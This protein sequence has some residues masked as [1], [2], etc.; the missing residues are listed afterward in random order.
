MKAQLVCI[1]MAISLLGSAGCALNY[2]LRRTSLVQ[3]RQYCSF[4]DERHQEKYFRKVAKQELERE[5]ATAMAN[6]DDYTCDPYS[7]DQ[8]CGFEDGFVDYVMYGGVGN[9]PSLPPRR[10][11]RAKYQNGSGYQAIQDWYSG[12]RQGAAVAQASG[13]RDCVIMQL[14]DGL[15]TST[16]PTYV[17]Q[18]SGLEYSGFYGPELSETDNSHPAKGNSAEATDLFTSSEP[19]GQELPS[20]ENSPADSKAKPETIHFPIITAPATPT[21]YH[22]NRAEPLSQSRPTYLPNGHLMSGTQAVSSGGL[23]LVSANETDSSEAS[24]LPLATQFSFES[25]PPLSA[26]PDL[27]APDHSTSSTPTQ[28]APIKRLPA[29]SDGGMFEP[30]SDSAVTAE[31][32]LMSWLAPVFESDA[33]AS[34]TSESASEQFAAQQASFVVPASSSDVAVGEAAQM[35]MPG[36]ESL[37]QQ[38]IPNFATRQNSQFKKIWPSIA[39]VALLVAGVIYLIRRR[40]R[41]IMLALRQLRQSSDRA[42]S[43]VQPRLDSLQT[44]MPAINQVENSLHTSIHA[45]TRAKVGMM[46]A[47]LGCLTSG[48]ASLTNPVLNGIPVRRL[49]TEL[50]SAPNRD[51]LQTIPLS[52]LRQQQPENYV[53]DAGDVIGVFVAGVFPLTSPE[54]P[55]PIPPVYFPS[56]IDPLG[57]GL[58]PSLGY[59]VTIRNDGT[60]AL[61]FVEPIKLDGLTIEE[62]NVRIRAAYLDQGI[63]QPGREEVLVTLMQPRRIRVL[64]FR[65]EVGGFS[66]GGRGDITGN[67]KLGTGHIVDLRAYENDVVTALANTGGLPGLDAFNGVFI[68][69][70]GQSNAALVQALP[71]LEPG[72]QLESVSDDLGIKV[73][74]IPVRW[75]KDEPLPFA[76]E[77]AILHEG[78]VVLLE[79]RVTDYYYTGGLL[80]SGQQVLPRDYDLDVVEAVAQVNGTLVNGAFGGNNFNG[81]LIQPGIGN[82]N[83][84]ALTVIRHT[85]DGGQIPIRVDL[86]RA[87]VDARERIII[88]PNDVLILQETGWEALARYF[89]NAIN[90]NVTIFQSGTGTATAIQGN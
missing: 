63:L 4:W 76:P 50:L 37:N 22:P 44:A 77:D 40:P 56:Q 48:C 6:S 17:G 71:N 72:E 53:L 74:Y 62:A 78:D 70:G 34:Q 14:S 20:I 5:R 69:R 85:P 66:S 43:R 49:P 32:A 68:F 7:A 59:P 79:S 39:G 24:A 41:I 82:P 54:Q 12:F 89:G 15:N 28:T 18:R 27:P 83:P 26:S 8:A 9:P 61:P 60:L 80:P 29:K 35:S 86:N 46:I 84:S 3:P 87:L 81:L 33:E 47:L 52:L 58:P 65:Q 57:A 30:Q 36:A 88:R 10:Y 75:A 67:N 64:V 45:S 23:K 51:R 42:S 21:I 16:L 25:L 31:H 55:L 11:W 90:F 13:Y 1:L 38:K 19:S 2:N 73:D